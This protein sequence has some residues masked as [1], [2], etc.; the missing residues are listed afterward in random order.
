MNCIINES[1]GTSEHDDL[2]NTLISVLL[3]LGNIFISEGLKAD[4]SKSK[5]ITMCINDK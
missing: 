2:K 1:R 5:D 3:S 4:P